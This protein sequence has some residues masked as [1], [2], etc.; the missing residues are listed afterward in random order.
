MNAVREGDRAEIERHLRQITLTDRPSIGEE[1]IFTFE[2]LEPIIAE[3]NRRLS[4]AGLSADWKVPRRARAFS[5][6]EFTEFAIERELRKEFQKKCEDC[7]IQIRALEIP[8]ELKR[9]SPRK[10]ESGNVSSL[11]VKD[12]A[13]LSRNERPKGS[14]AWPLQLEL[15][16]GS[17]RTSNITGIVEFFRTVPIATRAVQIGEKIRA[18]DRRMERRNVSY[19]LDEPAADFEFESSVSSRYLAAGEPVWRSSLKKEQIVRYGDTVRVQVASDMFSV[20]A[21]GVALSAAAVGDPIQVRVGSLK[22]QI[23]GVLKEKGLV[24]IR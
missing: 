21:E 5:Q 17:R 7:E 10:E 15:S 16:D 20:S 18:E 12:W 6:P 2:G 22:K 4:A 8:R 1:R 3:A 19:S 11:Y 23:S 13:I 24:E 14:F 9:W